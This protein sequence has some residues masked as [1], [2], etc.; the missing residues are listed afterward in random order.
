MFSTEK[1]TEKELQKI[2]EL[3]NENKFIKNNNEIYELGKNLYILFF[4]DKINLVTYN[5]NKL[6]KLYL[7]IYHQIK[8][9]YCKMEI[10]YKS[11]IID[12]NIYAYIYLGKYY[13]Y[14][15]DYEKM[16]LLYKSLI[17]PL[18]IVSLEK[19]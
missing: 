14:M 16:I 17:S 4:E 5:S 9:D 6:F 2:N 7:G 18:V 13:E 12:N 1:L 11:A 8:K 19:T 3:L 10:A 15:K